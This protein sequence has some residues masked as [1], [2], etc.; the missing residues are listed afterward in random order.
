LAPRE[1]EWLYWKLTENS[2][3][4]SLKTGL[5]F[6]ALPLRQKNIRKKLGLNKRYD[7]QKIAIKNE[8]WIIRNVKFKGNT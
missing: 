5:S 6:N 8:S 7:L 4:A 1:L 2:Y 3:G